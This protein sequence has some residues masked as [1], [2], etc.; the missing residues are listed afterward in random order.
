MEEKRFDEWNELKKE[1]H[2]SNSMPRIK[3]G[4]IWWCSFGE[5]IGEEINGKNRLFSRPVFVLKKLGRKGF[6]GIPLTSQKK[7]GSW[8]AKIDFQGKDEVAVLCQVRNIDVSR[9]SS[10]MG[11]LD[12]GD[13]AK[14]KEAFVDLIR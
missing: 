8:Y 7:E 13:I 5:N 11:E 2:N 3:E 14:I 9:L 10:R 6:L 4:D 1:L 12:E